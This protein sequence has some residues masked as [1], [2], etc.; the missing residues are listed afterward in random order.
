MCVNLL[1][2]VILGKPIKK[3]C[4]ISCKILDFFYIWNRDWNEGLEPNFIPKRTALVAILL[5]KV[6][7]CSGVVLNPIVKVSSRRPLQG[8]L[9][10]FIK[11][12]YC[13]SFALS[14][15]GLCCPESRTE[16]W[17]NFVEW[18][19]GCFYENLFFLFTIKAKNVI[20]YMFYW[21]ILITFQKYVIF[22]IF[23]CK[24]VNGI[25]IRA[26]G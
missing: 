6:T 4:F 1:K 25:M 21:K 14:P 15:L 19:P 13:I 10:V 2:K 16:F 22:L 18:V 24:L 26:E 3:R 9:F 7:D 8:A 12:H 23:L 17:I 5:C 11:R 20:S